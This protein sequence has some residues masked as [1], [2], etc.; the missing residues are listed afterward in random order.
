[1]LKP[2]SRIQRLASLEVPSK[3][4]RK[5]RIDRKVFSK[6]R[7]YYLLVMLTQKKFWHFLKLKK[8]DFSSSIL[9]RTQ[10]LRII[11]LDPDVICAV[12]VFPKIE[13][14]ILRNSHQKYISIPVYKNKPSWIGI[15]FHK[16]KKRTSCTVH[17]TASVSLTFGEL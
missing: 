14:N 1:M 4:T 7:F 11:I 5:S 9:F 8:S 3:Y 17:C 6:N 15:Y 13:K 12:V 10:G 16:S 2:W